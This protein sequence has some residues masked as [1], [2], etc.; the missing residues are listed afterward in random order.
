MGSPSTNKSRLANRSSV[1]GAQPIPAFE[2]PPL[3][4]RLAQIAP[5]EAKAWQAD[6][7]RRHAEW[8]AKVNVV[9]G[10]IASQIA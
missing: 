6:C 7:N 1:G 10:N 9:N 3:P 8:V 4:P 2:F 5:D